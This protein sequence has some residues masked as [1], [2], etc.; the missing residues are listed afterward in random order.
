MTL[1]EFLN[2]N[3]F[4]IDLTDSTVNNS[5]IVEFT[6]MHGVQQKYLITN[7]YVSALSLVLNMAESDY[8]RTILLDQEIVIDNDSIVVYDQY[9]IKTK[10]SFYHRNLVKL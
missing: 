3:K 4:D 8:P 1:K 2:N 5:V 10:M 6:Y 9:K 7:Y